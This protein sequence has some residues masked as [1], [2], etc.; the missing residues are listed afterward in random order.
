MGG[1]KESACYK[2][3]PESDYK[4]VNF[5]SPHYV[6]AGR[7]LGGTKEPACYKQIPESNDS[8]ATSTAPT[9]VENRRR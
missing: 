5:K 7:H 4:N 9:F 1:T 2:Q 8:L 3:I 6:G